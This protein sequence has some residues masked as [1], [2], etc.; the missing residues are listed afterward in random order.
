M[1]KSSKKNIYRKFRKNAGTNLR[2][3]AVITFIVVI[4]YAFA[5]L[6]L[7]SLGSLFQTLIGI[8]ISI[9][10]LSCLVLLVQPFIYSYFLIN[11]LEETDSE[12][13]FG[14]TE[15]FKGYLVGSKKPFSTM[16][17]IPSTLIFSFL[18]YFVSS[19]VVGALVNVIFYYTNADFKELFDEM[20]VLI[21]NNNLNKA[22]DLLNANQNLLQLPS[23]ITNFGA[24]LFAFYYFIHRV[25]VN[26]F[27]FVLV[28]YASGCDKRTFQM[29]YKGTLKENR[30]FFNSNYYSVLYPY[31]ILLVVIYSVSYFALYFL[32]GNN[33]STLILGLTSIIITILCLLPFLSVLF[34][35]YFEIADPFGILLIARMRTLIEEQIELIKNQYAGEKIPD[36]DQYISMIINGLNIQN[37]KAKEK[38]KE[39]EIKEKEKAKKEADENN[40][41]KKDN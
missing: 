10:F 20:M 17:L 35:F 30:K 28:P 9:I 31:L 22:N 37:E 24:I 12:H 16:L 6:V 4:V 40:E 34:N 11:T 38:Q 8:I 25:C 14:L 18:I 23:V 3:S 19:I 13:N 5:A 26:I 41:N 36:Q 32:L 39:L 15:F 2:Y 7:N 1:T 29:V 27:K 33:I 21:Q